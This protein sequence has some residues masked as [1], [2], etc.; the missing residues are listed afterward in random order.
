MPNYPFWLGGVAASMAACVT[1]P[2]DLTRVRMQTFSDS[3]GT[4]GVSTFAVLRASIAE[5]GFRSLYAGLSASLLRQMSYSL[6]RLGSYERIKQT[7]VANGTSSSGMLVVA[8]AL[9]GAMAGVVG[10]PADILLVRMTTD[11]TRPPEQRYGYSNALSGLVRLIKEEGFTAFTRGLEANITRAVLMNVS[12][13]ASYDYFKTLLLHRPLP[14]IDYHFH[15]GLFLHFVSSTLAGTVA[16]TICT[17]ADVVKSRMMSQTCTTGPLE[18]IRTSFREE[19]PKFLFKGWTP[20]FIR[21]VPNTILLF[22]FLE[23]LKQG[24]NSFSTPQSPLV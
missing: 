6:V 11:S 24:W 7:L 13:V 3:V 15:E 16:T 23:Q 19:G 5:S 8:A 21:L 17:P 9:A 1:H 4:K 2:L 18:L 12:Q 22:M 20:A 14:L 10:N